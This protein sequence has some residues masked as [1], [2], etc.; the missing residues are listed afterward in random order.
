MKH[1]N[2]QR[3]A[4][5]QHQFSKFIILSHA[6]NSSKTRISCV[7]VKSP[8]RW[9]RFREKG[10]IGLAIIARVVVLLL[11]F[12]TNDFAN[13]TKPVTICV[14]TLI[15]TFVACNTQTI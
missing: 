7:V 13:V 11:F 5:Q 9:V 14:Q 15:E 8:K 1:V 6:L 3:A 4:Q 2:C 10:N 12:T